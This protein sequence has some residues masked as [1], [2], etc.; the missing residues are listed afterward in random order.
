MWQQP[1]VG[2]GGGEPF[3]LTGKFSTS[4]HSEQNLQHNCYS[5]IFILSASVE[6]LSGLEQSQQKLTEY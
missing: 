5:N 6:N 2:G 1:V 4:E 3:F